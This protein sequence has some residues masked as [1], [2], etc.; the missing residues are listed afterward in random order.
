MRRALDGLSAARAGER[1]SAWFAGNGERVL[2]GVEAAVADDAEVALRVVT[3]LWGV[4]AGAE[5]DERFCT[6]LRGHGAE[7]SARVAPS[8]ELAEL[9]RA[10]AAV[11]IGRRTFE[12]AEVE[13]MRELKVRGALGD[14]AGEAVV[15]A[16]LSR[17]FRAQGRLRRVMDMSDELVALRQRTKDRPGVAQALRMVGQVL[18]EAGRP[19][20]AVRHLER[21]RAVQ[22]ECAG[23]APRQLAG[24][25]VL[26]GLARWLTGSR[27]IARKEFK[28]AAGV[29][30]DA[31]D[32]AA[33]RV[34]ALLAVP[35]RGDVVPEVG[36]LLWLG[37]EEMHQCDDDLY[38]QAAA[39]ADPAR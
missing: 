27:T 18:I 21:A 38:E 5:V 20:S 36:E 30:T 31:G 28:A 33:A 10:S 22:E 6:A 12:V 25:R 1:R 14:P 37:A 19:E 8:P 23:V 24:V 32:A 35:S 7:V 39:G 17:I 2:G 16:R 26:T 29:L 15:L 11:A 3:V 4:V 9:F 13:A 34:A